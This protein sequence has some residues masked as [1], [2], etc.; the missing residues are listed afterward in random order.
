MTMRRMTMLVVV[1]VVLAAVV[2]PVITAQTVESYQA[3]IERFLVR[4]SH[5]TVEISITVGDNDP[6]KYTLEMWT[7][8]TELSASVIVD[9][10]APFMLGLAFLEKEDKTTAWWPTIE[11][12]KTFDSS[13]SEE[14]V[15]LGMGRL[16]RLI[17][18]NE[19]YEATF[20]KETETGWKY[21]VTPRD[22]SV[23]DFSYG[24]IDVNKSDDTLVR[25]D[26]FDA[27][28]E[29][30]ETD[31]V[32]DYEA[33]ATHSGNTL[34]YPMSFAYEDF[35][36]NKKTTMEYSKIEFPASIDDSVFTLDFLKAQSAAAL[37]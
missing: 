37:N 4:Y 13:Q 29:A 27:N 15:G 31:T 7:K 19:D 34:L 9:A 30:I 14:E 26:F 28:D 35:A 5:G 21:R 1:Y 6:A 18:H 11:K 8:G 24:I 2:A 3:A 20:A 17:W 10:S 23:A 12:E 33:I 16:D 25:A 22:A 36:N 32:A